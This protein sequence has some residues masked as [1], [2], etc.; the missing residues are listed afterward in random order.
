M[1]LCKRVT[2]CG[3]VEERLRVFRLK[4]ACNLVGVTTS[5]LVE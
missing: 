1:Q 3:L 2:A 4:N 5:I